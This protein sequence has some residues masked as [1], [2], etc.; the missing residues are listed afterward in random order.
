M[1]TR[2]HVDEILSFEVRD[3]SVYVSADGLEF[4]TPLRK[5][6]LGLARAAKALADYDAKG[7]VVPL[8]R[9]RRNHAASRS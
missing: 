8:K 9:R 2:Q 7:E 6:R 1:P 3:S 5:F 4:V